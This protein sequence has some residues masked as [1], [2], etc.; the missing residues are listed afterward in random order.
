MDVNKL[1]TY[2][3]FRKRVRTPQFRRS[4]A[5]IIFFGILF[6]SNFSLFLY[7]QISIQRKN[8]ANHVLQ[9]NKNTLVSLIRQNWQIIK[10]SKALR[11]EFLLNFIKLNNFVDFG[12][13]L[14]FLQ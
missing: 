8:T 9:T 14:D 2:S 10:K 11:V 7:P 13:L 1:E 6:F 5:K 4:L 3:G 12:G